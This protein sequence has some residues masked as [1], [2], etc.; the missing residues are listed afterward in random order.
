M[1]AFAVDY[2]AIP[3]LILPHLAS[4]FVQALVHIQQHRCGQK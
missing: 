3:H 1:L 4:S 2:L